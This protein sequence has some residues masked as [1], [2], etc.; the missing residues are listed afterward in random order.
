[1]KTTFSLIISLFLVSACLA[2]AQI[3]NAGFE[4]MSTNPE[5]DRIEPD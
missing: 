5:T 3:I 2:D 4:S 1:M